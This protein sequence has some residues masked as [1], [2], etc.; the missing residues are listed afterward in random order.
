MAFKNT[1]AEIQK[2]PTK[3]KLPNWTVFRGRFGEAVTVLELGP[4]HVTFHSKTALNAQ[5]VPIGDFEKV[6]KLWGAYTKGRLTRTGVVEVTRY[7]RYIINT[8][9]WLCQ[10][11]KGVLS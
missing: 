2:I 7:S 8:F 6:Y 5:R 11:H 3:T 4:K 10:R 9:Q 1:W